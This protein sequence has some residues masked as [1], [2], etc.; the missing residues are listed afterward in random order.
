MGWQV[1]FA[2]YEHKYKNIRLVRDDGVLQISLHTD[3]DSFVWSGEASA[4][5]KDLFVNVAADVENKVAVITG[6]GGSFCV[7]G[8]EGGDGRGSKQWTFV[9]GRQQHPW[10]YYGGAGPDGPILISA[11]NGPVTVHCEVPLIADLVIAADTAYFQDTHLARGK[12]PG[13]G[14]Q[15]LW[16]YYMGPRLARYFLLTGKKVQPAQALAF[17]LV[18]EVVPADQVVARALT[19]AR[20]IAGSN[21]SALLRYMRMLVNER[22]LEITNRHHAYGRALQY[23]A[24]DA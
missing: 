24:Y 20:E 7:Q 10:V 14:I 17:G 15:E 13:D 23:L 1:P 19:L 6:T 22:Y 5:L 11:V 12:V 3:G 2:E 8:G 9:N 16:E 18:S 4:E 21:S